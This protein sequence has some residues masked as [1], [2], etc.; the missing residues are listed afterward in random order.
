[1]FS[2]ANVKAR[3]YEMEDPDTGMPLHIK[4]PKLAALQRFS[5]AFSNPSSTPA[6]AAEAIA[7]VLNRNTSGKRV[8]ADMVA[9]WMDSD[10][11]AEFIEDFLGWLNKEKKADPN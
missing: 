1:M 7:E 4:P 9:E 3:T 11:M 5:D 6:Q 10:Q 8:T 2:L